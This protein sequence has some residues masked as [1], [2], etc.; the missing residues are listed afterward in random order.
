MST[1]YWRKK[2]KEKWQKK[3]YISTWKTQLNA[4]QR[5]RKFEEKIV[6]NIR[7]NEWSAGD[8]IS[9]LSGISPFRNCANSILS[10][11]V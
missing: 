4:I 11:R 6:K 5:E 9:P 1:N 7:K 3:P 8:C 2:P 10:V